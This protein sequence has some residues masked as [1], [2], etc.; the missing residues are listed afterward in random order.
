[1]EKHDLTSGTGLLKCDETLFTQECG[2]AK[3][4]VH[5]MMENIIP[6]AKARNRLPSPPPKGQV[7]MGN[8]TQEVPKHPD[9]RRRP[10]TDDNASFFSGMS[11]YIS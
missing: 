10:P 2:I 9:N 11:S 8:T 5:L 7:P 3:S 4:H 6:L 1:M